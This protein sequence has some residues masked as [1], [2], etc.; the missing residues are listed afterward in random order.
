F[1]GLSKVLGHTENVQVTAY[2][3]GFVYCNVVDWGNSGS[4]L[5]VNVECHSRT[6]AMTDNLF[7]ILAIE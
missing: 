7:T 3:G 4:A 2:G 6:G 5:L 1:D